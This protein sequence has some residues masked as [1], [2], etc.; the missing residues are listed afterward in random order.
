MR[1]RAF[2]KIPL[3]C[4]CHTLEKKGILTTR[5]PDF[6]GQAAQTYGYAGNKVPVAY[7]TGNYLAGRTFIAMTY[8]DFLGMLAVRSKSCSTLHSK[9]LPGKTSDQT[10]PLQTRLG[11]WGSAGPWSVGFRT[12]Q[13]D[14]CSTGFLS[15][16]GSRTT[17]QNSKGFGTPVEIII[18]AKY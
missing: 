17:P 16:L 3:S 12:I 14:R 5:V 11:G 8:L 1:N 9:I 6:P 18:S 2:A 4:T 7:H 13:F 10:V 15:K